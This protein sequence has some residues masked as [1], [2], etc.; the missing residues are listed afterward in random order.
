M[1]ISSNSSSAYVYGVANLLHLATTIF[2]S[3]CDNLVL[4]VVWTYILDTSCLLAMPVSVK[5]KF[6][7]YYIKQSHSARI[8]KDI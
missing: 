8:L 4:Y 1:P 3:T 5:N 2:Y 6:I 7:R